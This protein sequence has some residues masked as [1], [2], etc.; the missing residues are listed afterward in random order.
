MKVSNSYVQPF[1]GALFKITL[2]EQGFEVSE[3]GRYII[4]EKNGQ[5]YLILKIARLLSCRGG[6]E[7]SSVVCAKRLSV[8]KLRGESNRLGLKPALAFGVS[9]YDFRDSEIVIVPLDVWEIS[10][11]PAWLSET[12]R[13]YFFNYKHINEG[14]IKRAIIHANVQIQYDARIEN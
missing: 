2:K 7:E 12:P 11:R 4:A 5:K 14:E 13:G 10:N 3:D 6:I 9:K 8:E 1:M